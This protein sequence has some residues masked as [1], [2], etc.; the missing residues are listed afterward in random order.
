MSGTLQT[1]LANPSTPLETEIAG[2]GP[3]FHNLHLPDGTQTAPDH[4]LGDFP[5]FKWAQLSDYVPQDLTGWTV[6][7]IGCNSGFYSFELARRGATVRAV[8]VEPHYLRQARWAAEIYGLQDRITFEEMA[9]YD[10]GREAEQYDIVWF[11]GVLYHLRY[12]LLALDIIGRKVKQLM[13]MQSLTTED[14]E[15]VTETRNLGF[16]DIPRM[17]QPGWPQMAFVENDLLGDSTNWWLPNEACMQAMLRSAGFHIEAQPAQG[18]FVCRPE[19][20]EFPF[21]AELDAAVGGKR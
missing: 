4:P 11:M 7:D 16:A 20:H 14:R 18:T 15:V 3:W 1:Q 9:L 17:T 10:L 6:L 13:V 21:Q 12:P 8:D 5:S 19:A 2:M